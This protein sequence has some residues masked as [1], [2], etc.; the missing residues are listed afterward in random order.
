MSVSEA[1]SASTPDF[2][3]LVRTYVGVD[4]SAPMTELARLSLASGSA[5]FGCPSRTRGIS[6]NLAMNFIRSGSLQLWA[7]TA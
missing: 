4:Y 6:A 3:P 1:G 7:L 5:M 2:A